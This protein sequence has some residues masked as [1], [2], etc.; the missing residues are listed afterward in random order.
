M[1]TYVFLT[2]AIYGIGGTQ[3]YVR[4]KLLFLRAHGWNVIVVSSEPGS[5]L[6]IRE[7][8]E[9]T[10]FVVP[11][12]AKNPYQSDRKRNEI[13]SEV[14]RKLSNTVGELVIESNYINANLWGEWLAQRLEAKHFAYLIQEIYDMKSPKY[15][16][17][18]DFKYTRGELAGNTR[19]A[20]KMLF[21][22]YRSVEENDGDLLQFVTTR[23]R[24]VPLRKAFQ[25]PLIRLEALGEST[26]HLWD[27]WWTISCVSPVNIK[28]I[29]F[30]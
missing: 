22:S 2:F 14:Q 4:N 26:N 9:F 1:K 6:V 16:K 28:R 3:I 5:D 19:Y 12:L 20:L 8:G 21:G 24:T 27:Q 23:L 17:F 11:E 25:R 10:D 29:L 7:L 30:F 13:L 18:Y 15:L